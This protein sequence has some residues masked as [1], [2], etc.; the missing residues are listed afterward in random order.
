MGFHHLYFWY[1]AELNV[2]YKDIKNISK[3][4]ITL[5]LFFDEALALAYGV[6]ARMRDFTDVAEANA[7]A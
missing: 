4:Q 6:D 3:S 1:S 2:Q 7:L 5:K